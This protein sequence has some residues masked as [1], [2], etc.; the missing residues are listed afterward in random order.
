[1]LFCVRITLHKQVTPVSGYT[2]V[3]DGVALSK[4]RQQEEAMCHKAPRGSVTKDLTLAV[5]WGSGPSENTRDECC[6]FP[7]EERECDD[8]LLRC[9]WCSGNSRRCFSSCPW[10]C[11]SSDTAP[12]TLRVLGWSTRVGVRVRDRM[13]VAEHGQSS[14]DLLWEDGMLSEK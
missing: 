1:M 13:W 3:C 5:A 12:A 6:C 2:R 10:L 11:L 14:E 9:R 7:F 8:P 4:G